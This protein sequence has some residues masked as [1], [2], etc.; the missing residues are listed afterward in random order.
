MTGC[1]AR[2][3]PRDLLA[4]STAH[5]RA[6]CY[7]CLQDGLALLER[8]VDLPSRQRAFELAVLLAARAKELGLPFEPWAERARSVASGLP[9][10]AAASDFLAL[11]DALRRDPSGLDR[12][13]DL[14]QRLLAVA[15]QVPAWLASIESSHASIEAKMY[16]ALA[17]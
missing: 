8:S 15:H 7:R 6:G 14:G 9:P 11:V 10:A 1:A 13:Q 2:Q 16:F 4:E 3:P 17:G 5:L 12:D